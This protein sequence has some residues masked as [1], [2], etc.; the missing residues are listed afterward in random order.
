MTKSQKI[1]IKPKQYFICF[2]LFKSCI[3]LEFLIK[4]IFQYKGLLNEY[5]NNCSLIFDKEVNLLLLRKVLCPAGEQIFQEWKR[6]GKL[7]CSKD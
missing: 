6:A 5:R 7:V 1:I 3:H 4:D 2:L